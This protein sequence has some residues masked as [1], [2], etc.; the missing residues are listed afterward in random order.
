MSLKNLK[1]KREDFNRNSFKN[2]WKNLSLFSRSQVSVTRRGL[3]LS[4][5]LLACAGF[6]H[7]NL[8]HVFVATAHADEGTSTQPASQAAAVTSA[9]STTTPTPAASDGDAAY[10][11]IQNPGHPTTNDQALTEAAMT[12][13]CLSCLRDQSPSDRHEAW[14]KSANDAARLAAGGANPLPAAGNGG[15]VGD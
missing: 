9:L 15:S 5:L 12:P 4:L 13:F 11:E 10:F 14:D 2:K 8:H 1:N 7:L 6:Y 3:Q